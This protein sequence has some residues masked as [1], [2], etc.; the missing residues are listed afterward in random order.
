LK[1]KV[2]QYFYLLL[3]IQFQFLTLT[4]NYAL[5]HVYSNELCCKNFHGCVLILFPACSVVSSARVAVERGIGQRRGAAG[6][7]PGAA[8]G[9]VER[10][11]PGAPAAVARGAAERCG[12]P[13]PTRNGGRGR[14][15]PKLRPAAAQ[16]A[17]PVADRHPQ[18]RATPKT[19]LAA[20]KHDRR[21]QRRGGTSAPG[22]RRVSHYLRIFSFKSSTPESWMKCVL[23]ANF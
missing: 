3:S 17:L 11:R 2:L 7:K 6:R 5:D 15:G 10:R 19:A 13:L 9:R 12:A 23:N 8:A 1:Y 20:A 22:R 4:Y 14:V 16:P 21:N 18:G